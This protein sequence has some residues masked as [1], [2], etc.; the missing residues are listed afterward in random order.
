MCAYLVRNF[1]GSFTVLRAG[2]GEK[3]NRTAFRSEN[4]ISASAC[5]GEER[6]VNECT[7]FKAA[8]L[9]K[10]HFYPA[11]PPG[12]ICGSILILVTTL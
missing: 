8:P 12:S 5:Q 1:K 2:A 3:K 10:L 6:I 9:S 4:T 11:I 7:W